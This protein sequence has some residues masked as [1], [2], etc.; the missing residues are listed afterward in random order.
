[1][2]VTFHYIDWFADGR[3]AAGAGGFLVILSRRLRGAEA[4]RW[5]A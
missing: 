3:G 4:A 5:L 2:N 1:V